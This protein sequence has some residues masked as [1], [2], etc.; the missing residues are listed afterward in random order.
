M[1]FLLELIEQYGLLFVFANVLLEQLGAPIPAYPTLVITGALLGR[2]EYSAPMLLFVA[3][4]AALIADF[5]WYLAGRRYGARVMARLCRISLSPDSCVRQTESI[6][7]RFGPA[8]LLVAKFIPGF[9]SVASALAGAIGTRSVKFIFFD[10]LGAA[11]WSGS[12]IFLGSLFSSAVSDL[13]DILASLG[14]WGLVLVA[15]ALAIYI[16]RKWWQR[17]SFL[18]DL[19]MARIS[20]DELDQLLKQGNPPTIIDVRSDFAQQ[21]GRIPGAMVLSDED[22]SAL[23]INTET[24]S[25]V[26]VYCACPNE[27]SAARIAR[28]LMQRGYTRVRP[29]TGGIDA[30]VEAGFSVDHH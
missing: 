18:K 19:R 22:I 7:L 4:L 2:G 5:A 25:E 10:A 27:V 14:K 6:Y 20:V 13:L 30:W 1:S 21:S 11:L 12:A 23:V 9:A 29:L 24:D 28:K 3:V 26:I 17:H 8:S 16:A 15:V